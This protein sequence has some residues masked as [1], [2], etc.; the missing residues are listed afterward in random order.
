MTPLPQQL[1]RP[2][3]DLI[4]QLQSVW[5]ITIRS[6]VQ[7]RMEPFAV[8]VEEGGKEVQALVCCETWCACPLLSDALPLRH[9]PLRGQWKG[10]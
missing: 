6:P 10:A 4:A 3:T 7:A 2:T 1:K 8:V 5:L 9:S